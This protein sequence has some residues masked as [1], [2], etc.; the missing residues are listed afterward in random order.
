MDDVLIEFK[1]KNN[2]YTADTE[3]RS[4]ISVLDGGGPD[5]LYICRCVL[6]NRRHSNLCSIPLAK[7][8]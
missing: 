5:F 8:R 1:L 3:Q 2:I 6:H 7:W 4:P